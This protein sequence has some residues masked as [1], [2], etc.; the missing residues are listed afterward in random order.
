MFEGICTLNISG[1]ERL[2]WKLRAK[3]V[4]FNHYDVR[5]IFVSDSI[6]PEGNHNAGGQGAWYDSQNVGCSWEVA[7]IKG[8]T[9]AFK[10]EDNFK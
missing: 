9:T 2:V 4:L 1:K 5:L 10:I 3:F 7:S 6:A 8:Q